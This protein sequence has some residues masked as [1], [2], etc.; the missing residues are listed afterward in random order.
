MKMRSNLIALMTFMA[1]SA[2]A[3]KVHEVFEANRES[4][5][6]QPIT[7]CGE[8]AFS[9]G[10]AQSPRNRGDAIGYTKADS[11]AKWNLGERFRLT[12]P[13]PDDAT[14]IERREAWAE[15]R[16][17]HPNR[18]TVW[19]MQRILTKKI[20]PD[21]YLVVL[22]FPAEQVN[23]PEPTT[24]ELVKA[25]SIVR[26]RRRLAEE[27][28]RK[29]S[30]TSVTNTI[31]LVDTIS[32]PRLPPASVRNDPEDCS[33]ENKVVPEGKIKKFETFDEDMML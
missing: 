28:A 32:V 27:M 30:Q 19:G 31:P 13:W 15:Y 6:S 23:V 16:N 5:L 18:F 12:A 33:G 9:V 14:E 4:V 7:I 26:E 8:F 3:D 29:V 20:P 10:R 11:E 22:G 1:L 2:S 17:Q 21:N 25:V 24:A